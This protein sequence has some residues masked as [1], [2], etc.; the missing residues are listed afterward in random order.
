MSSS[1]SLRAWL[2]AIAALSACGGG[3]S[4]PE[5]ATCTP[6][7]DGT[8]TQAFYAD[9]DSYCMVQIRD[10][11]IATL[12]SSVVAYDL[13]TPL[14]ADYA[15]KRRTV[16]V[17]PGTT[18]VYR[19][20]EVFD[21]PVGTL[22]TKSFGF[23]R[24]PSAPDGPV[25]WVETR[26]LVRGDAGWK[27]VAYLWNDEQTKALL[28][29]GGAIRPVDVRG[30]TGSL[31]HA[32]Y[33]VPSQQ[34]CPKC[35]DSITTFLPIGLRASA[36]DHGEQLAHWSEAGILAGL[37]EGR[38]PAPPAWTDAGATLA[39]RARAYLDGNCAFCHGPKGEARTTGLYLGFEEQDP[40]RLGTCKPPVAAGTATGNLRFDVVPGDPDSSLLSKRMIA[41]EP[42]LAMPEI[43]RSVVHEEGVQLVRAWIAGM[44]GGCPVQPR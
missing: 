22:I 5:R 38:K 6:G 32:S 44:S 7:G 9:L 4:T 35:H 26:V 2:F 20:D 8:Y 19:Q 40:T 11:E 39:T 29:P 24:D 1:H 41:T 16:W 14:F 36:L 21:F 23:P 30:P 10:G 42:A 34:Q 25:R 18:A 31:Q 3:S 43:S 28:Q 33:L 17:P 37:P 15:L 12:S 27:G 13:V